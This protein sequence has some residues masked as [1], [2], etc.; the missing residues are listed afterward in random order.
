[1]N[2]PFGQLSIYIGPLWFPPIPPVLDYKSQSCNPCS[3]PHWLVGGLLPCAD[4]IMY[5]YGQEAGGGKMAPWHFFTN[6]GKTS[7]SCTLILQWHCIIWGKSSPLPPPPPISKL[8]SAIVYVFPCS[9]ALAQD[10]KLQTFRKTGE[11]W[12]EKHQNVG[13]EQPPPPYPSTADLT[14]SVVTSPGLWSTSLEM[15]ESI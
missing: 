4:S 1:M 13:T 6:S 14:L 7:Y 15:L 8:I 9:V 10:P 2:K 3:G 5:A 11:L 12:R